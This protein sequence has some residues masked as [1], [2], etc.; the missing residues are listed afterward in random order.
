MN[1]LALKPLNN[2]STV[3][4][5]HVIA[6]DNREN[7]LFIVLRALDHFKNVTSRFLHYENL[8]IRLYMLYLV[9][10]IR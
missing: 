6:R 2:S 10:E 5:V 1:S 4:M 7:W 3:H 9:T 8:R